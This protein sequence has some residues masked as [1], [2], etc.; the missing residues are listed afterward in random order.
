MGDAILS[1][2]HRT[3]CKINTDEQKR[4]YKKA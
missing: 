2:K 3:K 1:L 4:D